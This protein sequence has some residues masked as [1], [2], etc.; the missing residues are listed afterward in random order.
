MDFKGRLSVFLNIRKKK[1]KKWGSA[2]L[3]LDAA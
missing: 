1:K 2:H 3:A